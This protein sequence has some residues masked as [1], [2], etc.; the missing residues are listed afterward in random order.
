MLRNDLALYEEHADQWWRPRGPFVMLH[1]LAAARGR[2]VPAAARPDAVLVDLGCGAGL[3]APHL[4]G[5]GYRHIG[6][7]RSAASLRQAAGS[8]MHAVLGDVLAVPLA[9]GC[10]DVVVAGEILEH[11]PDLRGAVAEACRLLRPGGVLVIDT[12]AD[13]ALCR[14]IAIGLAE[15]VGLAP[16]G[17]HDP[18]LLVDREALRE[19]CARHGVRLALRGLR[20]SLTDLAAWSVRRRPSVRMVPSPTTAVLFQGYGRKAA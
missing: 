18:D 5:K 7:D 19:E 20:P 4:A 13:T 6:V 14:W 2:L 15:S 1:W 9:D 12:L 17:V 16:R 11:V 3:L 10:A 8:G